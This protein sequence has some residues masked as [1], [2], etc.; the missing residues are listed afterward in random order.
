MKSKQVMKKAKGIKKKGSFWYSMLRIWVWYFLRKFYSRIEVSGIKKLPA[1]GPVLL[2]ANHRNALMDALLL[3]CINPRPINFLA[4]SSVFRLPFDGVLRYLNML[5]VYRE[6]DGWDSLEKNN[7]VFEECS[8]RL[9]GGEVIAIFP[10]GRHHQEEYLFPLK[11]G[12]ARIGYEAL[13]NNCGGVYIQPV[14]INYEKIQAYNRR[15]YIRYGDGFMLEWPADYTEEDLPKFLSDA[16]SKATEAMKPTIIDMPGGEHYPAAEKFYYRWRKN[17]MKIWYEHWEDHF[18]EEK[19][20]ESDPAISNIVQH[21]FV[22]QK[23][24]PYGLR[25]LWA[26]GILLFA[27]AMVIIGLLLVLAKFITSKI[28][29]EI[30]FFGTNY[31]VIWLSLCTL[32]TIFTVFTLSFSLSWWQVCIA[33]GGMA[34]LFN[35]GART[36]NRIGLWFRDRE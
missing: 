27:P 22:E 17:W 21:H 3:G 11:K 10:E 1:T 6:R 24:D 7:G 30:C 18:D 4:R 8:M 20:Y 26:L 33:L 25:R 31:F 29:K 5:P 9:A 16:R 28:T 2:L 13:V 35:G 12:F 32:F 15:V 36:M 23:A 14:G 19:K 34:I